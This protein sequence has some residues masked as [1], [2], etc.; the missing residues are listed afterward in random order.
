MI[1][2]ST[3]NAKIATCFM[4]TG[5]SREI[6]NLNKIYTVGHKKHQNVFRHNFRKLDGF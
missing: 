3:H 4:D 1:N 5:F 2:Y 6:N